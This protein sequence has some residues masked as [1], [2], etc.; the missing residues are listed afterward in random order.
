MLPLSSDLDSYY[1]LPLTPSQGPLQRIVDAGL[2]FC[3]EWGLK[4]FQQRAVDQ[5]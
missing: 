1:L 5:G 4:R 2:C 3:G